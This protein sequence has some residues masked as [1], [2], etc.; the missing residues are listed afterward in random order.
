VFPKR[1]PHSLI[2]LHRNDEVFVV[3]LA[4]FRRKPAYWNPLVGGS[5]DV[6]Q[7]D[8]VA[9]TALS[10]LDAVERQRIFSP[11]DASETVETRPAEAFAR[12]VGL[13][14]FAWCPLITSTWTNVAGTR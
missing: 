11:K 7:F 10:G 2:Y 13:T 8:R 1:F 4:P 5:L 9:R 14:F 3:A 12:A 6:G